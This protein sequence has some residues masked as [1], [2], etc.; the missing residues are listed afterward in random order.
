[1][2]FLWNYLN[3]FSAWSKFYRTLKNTADTDEDVRE[4]NKN[5]SESKLKPFR[6]I[7]VF[8]CQKDVEKCVANI[9]NQNLE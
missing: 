9:R 6:S 8:H 3:T 1:M 7:E 4:R 2:T 5:D